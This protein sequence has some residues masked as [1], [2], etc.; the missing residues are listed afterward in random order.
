M[1]N[2]KWL[3]FIDDKFE[4]VLC[5]GCLSLMTICILTQVFLRFVFSSAAPWAEELAVYSMIFAVYLGASMAIKERSHIR[6]LIIVNLLPKWAQ[7]ISIMIADLIWLGFLV[8]MIVQTGIYM[9]LL[10]NTVYIS[11]GLGIDQKWFQL[12]VPFCFALMALRMLQV[13]YRWFVD[14]NKELPL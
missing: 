7:L 2:K 5:G 13:Y 4:E 8:L 14:K 12:T 9:E 6:I 1:L 11:P 10:F 3:H